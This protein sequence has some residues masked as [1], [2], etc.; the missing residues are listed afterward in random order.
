LDEACL[1]SGFGVVAGAGDEEGGAVWCVE[2]DD[3]EAAVALE[4][5]RAVDEGVAI[6]EVLVD[7]ED[8]SGEDNGGG[9]R[10]EDAAASLFGEGAEEFLAGVEVRAVV[11]EEGI[12]GGFSL[13]AD[14]DDVLR[15][16]VALV[17]DAV[18]EEEDGVGGGFGAWGLGG[19]VVA[20]GAVEG[21]PDG[22]AAEAGA[23]FVG[24]VGGGGERRCG[25]LVQSC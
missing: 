20:A 21:V 15:A 14:V 24:D 5:F 3:V 12:D 9:L 22:G 6:A 13:L 25:S 23:V 17:V 19:D 16:G 7:G 4:F 18:G 8:G 2:F 11:G 10:V 1:G